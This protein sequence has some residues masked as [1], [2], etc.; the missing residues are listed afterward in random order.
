M[1]VSGGY[2]SHSQTAK[3]LETLFQREFSPEFLRIE[4]E[5]HLHAGHAGARGGGGHFRVKIVSE[6]FSG[7][8]PL[9]R[10]RLVF[11]VVGD[12]MKQEIHALSME[13]RTPLEAAN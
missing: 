7:L 4:D 2:L 9:A 5:S 1:R 10:Q 6:K 3:L 13:C 11:A 8:T 12:L